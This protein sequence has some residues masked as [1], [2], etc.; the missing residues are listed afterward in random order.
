MITAVRKKVAQGIQ[1]IKRK[2]D[3][4]EAELSM[5]ELNII[6]KESQV[7]SKQANLDI[8][9]RSKAE[10]MIADRKTSLERGIRN[11]SANLEQMY[12]T[13][14]H[15]MQ[16]KYK[17]MTIG[18]RS[19]VFFTL[20]YGIASTIIT[21]MKTE[22]VRADFILF[23]NMCGKSVKTVFGWSMIVAGYGAKLGDLIPQ[24]IIATVVH[25]LIY[26]AI[27]IGFVGTC[28]LL[29]I[30]LGKKYIDFIRKKQV[31]E[32][33]VFAGLVILLIMV[34]T[35]DIIKSIISINLFW[36]GI[37]IFMVYTV[38]RGVLQA[39][40]EEV[41]KQIL[42]CSVIAGGSIGAIAA[43]IHFFGT[44]GLIAIPIGLLIVEGS[45]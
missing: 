32:I 20:F 21:A 33:S 35:A 11:K 40:N 39:E 13:R 14:T 8:E 29:I 36:L 31:D 6:S 27:V 5:R 23:L 1:A 24:A 43:M 3:T 10:N 9:I 38:V 15:D 42:K 12:K 37:I 30:V 19:M 7:A 4:K 16:A 18:Y 17:K 2:Y 44:I 25:W 41:K 45:K 22:V 28:G 26:V 34:F